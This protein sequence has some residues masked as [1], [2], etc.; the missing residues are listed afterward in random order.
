MMRKILMVVDDEA[1]LLLV[2]SIRLKVA[3]YDVIEAVDGLKALDL[4]RQK[5]PDLIIL[6][7]YLPGMNGDEV[8]R[9]LKK[10]EKTKRIPI[11]LISADARTLKERSGMCGA[12][13]YLFKPFE[14]TE[15]LGMIEKYIPA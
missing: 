15:L 7:V 4:A 3:G 1:D 6:D 13:G 10:E 9:Q 2:T 12:D 14:S 11:I 8:A 5:A